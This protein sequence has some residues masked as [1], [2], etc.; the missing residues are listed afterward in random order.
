M[1]IVLVL[2]MINCCITLIVDIRCVKFSKWLLLFQTFG[3]YA[4]INILLTFYPENNRILLEPF[5]T[6]N[7]GFAPQFSP[8]VDVGG[9]EVD[10]GDQSGA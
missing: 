6:L 1:W 2:F 9:G 10:V 7:L 3:N 4:N 5:Q 8:M